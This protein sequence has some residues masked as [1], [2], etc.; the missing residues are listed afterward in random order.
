[1]AALAVDALLTSRH[2]PSARIVPSEPTVQR[3]AFVPLQALGA[4]GGRVRV[5]AQRHR[6]G[7]GGLTDD[8]VG[9]FIGEDRVHHRV[10]VDLAFRRNHRH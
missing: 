1:L 7:V 2:L 3:C 4:A 5:D 6:G 8:V 10:V 9:S